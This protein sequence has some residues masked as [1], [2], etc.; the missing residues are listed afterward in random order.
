MDLCPRCEGPM[1]AESE[2][3][4][5]DERFRVCVRCSGEETSLYAVLYSISRRFYPEHWPVRKRKIVG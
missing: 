1:T 2:V 4:L 3:S 5:A